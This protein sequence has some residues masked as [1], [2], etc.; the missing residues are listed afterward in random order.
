MTDRRAQADE[1]AACRQPDSQPN[2]GTVAPRRAPVRSH[3]AAGHA[4][5]TVSGTAARSPLPAKS[6]SRWMKTPTGWS[7][8]S[9]R[10]LSPRLPCRWRSDRGCRDQADAPQPR[11]GC[12][13][14][15]RGPVSRR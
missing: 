12:V 1:A 8:G 11:S 14:V 9:V 6:T 4:A 15:S 3:T 7:S 10:A 5:R 2:D 13:V